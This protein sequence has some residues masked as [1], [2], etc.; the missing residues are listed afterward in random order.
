LWYQ[1]NHRS[2]GILQGGAMNH[3]NALPNDGNGPNSQDEMS[4]GRSTNV[5]RRFFQEDSV[6]AHEA[7]AG[8]RGNPAGWTVIGNVIWRKRLGESDAV[9]L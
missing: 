6:E 7:K 8:E 5:G 2:S 3:F 4:L 9:K 1:T